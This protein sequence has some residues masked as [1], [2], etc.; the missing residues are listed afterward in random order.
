MKS[1]VN[2]SIC[3]DNNYGEFALGTVYWLYDRNWRYFEP[4]I[5]NAIMS[6]D[7][8]ESIKRALI[9]F[10]KVSP[11]LV[12]NLVEFPKA[13]DDKLT[14]FNSYNPDV[15]HITNAAFYRL[16]LHELITDSKT[17]YIDIDTMP[18]Q[19]AKDM[20]EKDISDYVLA[21]VVD[22]SLYDPP[23]MTAYPFEKEAYKYDKVFS[24]GVMLLNLDKLRSIGAD[25]LEQ[26]QEITKVKELT[27]HDMTFLN[28][29]YG[30][31]VLWLDKRFNQ[32]DLVYSYGIKRHPFDTVFQSLLFSTKPW[33]KEGRYA[34][35]FMDRHVKYL[36]FEGMNFVLK[37]A[38]MPLRRWEDYQ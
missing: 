36:F 14:R 38:N 35:R 1:N 2:F 18:W 5:I 6:Y 34:N 37:L 21:A 10:D 30:K 16:F 13:I 20:W 8:D 28:D 29:T 4:V 31:D 32:Q 23:Y 33:A 27:H 22:L 7:V 25:P 11:G 9:E 12:I 17:I 26:L 15:P 24:S 19:S 3:F